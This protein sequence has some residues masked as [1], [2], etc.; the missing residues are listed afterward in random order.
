[1]TLITTAFAKAATVRAEILGL[2]A[3]P[4]VVLPHPL[5]SRKADEARAIAASLVDAIA[6]GLAGA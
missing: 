5:A 4:I 6:D 2:D 1:V 3:L